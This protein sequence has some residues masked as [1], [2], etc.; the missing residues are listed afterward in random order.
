MWP[1]FSVSWNTFQTKGDVRA[2]KSEHTL[3]PDELYT[4]ETDMIGDKEAKSYHNPT[5]RHQ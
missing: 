5:E 4:A 2:C 3:E 1:L